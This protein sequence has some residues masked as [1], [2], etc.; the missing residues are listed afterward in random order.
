MTSLI[1]DVHSL[2]EDR[3]STRACTHI[4]S[5]GGSR[6]RVG[7]MSRLRKVFL[8]DF[9]AMPTDR[10]DPETRCQFNQSTKCHVDY[11]AGQ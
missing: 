7:L 11:V 1:A 6:A 4:H 2:L 10:W 5:Q 8:T 3:G 9:F